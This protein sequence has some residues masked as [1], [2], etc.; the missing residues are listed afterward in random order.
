[1]A[2]KNKKTIA[3][4][5]ATQKN[6][7]LLDTKIKVIEDAG[8]LAYMSFSAYVNKLIDDDL[9]APHRTT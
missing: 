3:G 6:V 2:N 4:Q 7:T 5:P 8:K 9:S 1:M